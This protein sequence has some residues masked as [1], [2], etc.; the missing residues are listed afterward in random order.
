MQDH[1]NDSHKELKLCRGYYAKHLENYRFI[2]DGSGNTVH[3]KQPIDL[4]MAYF[5]QELPV[6]L[7]SKDFE[8]KPGKIRKRKDRSEYYKAWNTMVS[9]AK[10]K[11]TSD[12]NKD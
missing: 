9:L 6:T 1:R 5:Q 7:H 8:R 11:M 12:I 3:T 10:G 2:E 4:V